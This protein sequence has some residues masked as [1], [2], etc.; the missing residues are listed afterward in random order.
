[1][2]MKTILVIFLGCFWLPAQAQVDSSASSNPIIFTVVETHPEYS[3]GMAKLQKYIRQNLRYPEAAR[4]DR[5]EGTVFIRFVI[6]DTGHIQNVQVLK[7]VDPALDAEAVRLVES[8]PPW[9]PGKQAG[10]AVNV[11]YNLP[12]RFR[13]NG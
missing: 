11:R 13:L 5:R 3:G 4:K 10:K 1:M 12:I 9:Q 2:R 7:P 8:M 6:T